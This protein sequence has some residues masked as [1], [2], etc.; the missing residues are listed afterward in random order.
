[1]VTSSYGDLT[2]EG[3]DGIS[4]LA[5]WFAQVTC[6]QSRSRWRRPPGTRDIDS[7]GSGLAADARVEAE[8]ARGIADR[9]ATEPSGAD[10]DPAVSSGPSLR[11]RPRRPRR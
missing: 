1:M 4:E 3:G 2:S 5:G 8:R 10:G 9:Y 6:P 7:A 11:V